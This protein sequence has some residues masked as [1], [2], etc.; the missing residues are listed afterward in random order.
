MYLLD[1]NIIAT[2]LLGTK[3]SDEEINIHDWLLQKSGSLYM[4]AISVAEIEAG[5]AKSERQG[6]SRKAEDL[7]RWLDN[8][9]DAYA[10]RILPLD[11]VSARLAGR[12]LDKA[13]GAGG[14]PDFEDAAIAA[15]A[16]SKHFLV[17]TRNARHFQLFGVPFINPYEHLP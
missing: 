16:H 11:I 5:I 10:D 1:T 14:S 6:A 8:V 17:L 3:P 4:C 2:L 7:S 13:Y 9:L 12:L 15:I